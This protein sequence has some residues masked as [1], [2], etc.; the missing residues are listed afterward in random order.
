[1]PPGIAGLLRWSELMGFE[2]LQTLHVAAMGGLMYHYDRTCYGGR[3]LGLN[4]R[5]AKIPD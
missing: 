5:F 4:S 2:E 1:M 3:R